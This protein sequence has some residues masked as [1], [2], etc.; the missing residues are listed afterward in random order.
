MKDLEQKR[1]LIFGPFIDPGYSH[2]LAKWN[3]NLTK[4][5]WA[6]MDVLQYENLIYF[7]T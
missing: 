4:S 1:P 6:K 3:M 2:D 5:I 7:A